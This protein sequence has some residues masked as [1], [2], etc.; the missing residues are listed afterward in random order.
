MDSPEITT[1][2]TQLPE[3]NPEIVQALLL[4]K[5]EKEKNNYLVKTGRFAAKL[6]VRRYWKAVFEAGGRGEEPPRMQ[7]S[8]IPYLVLQMFHPKQGFAHKDFLRGRKSLPAEKQEELKKLS[9]EKME[10]K[11]KEQK[12]ADEKAKKE[13]AIELPIDEQV[14][15]LLPPEE[16]AKLSPDQKKDLAMSAQKLMGARASKIEAQPKKL[17]LPPGY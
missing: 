14:R 12:E 16:L 13:S 5:M 1:P 15:G 8:G 2:D 10:A 3:I 9:A 6:K 7:D 11:I 4:K 17:I